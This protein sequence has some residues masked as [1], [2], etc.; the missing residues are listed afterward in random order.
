MSE[1]EGRE[2]GREGKREGG[3]E[4]GRGE[5]GTAALQLERGCVN[6]IS[7]YASLHGRECEGSTSSPSLV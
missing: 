4:G 2:G 5:G 7:V 1:R 6:L 3:R